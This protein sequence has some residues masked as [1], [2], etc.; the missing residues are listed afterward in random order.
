MRASSNNREEEVH[1]QQ[2]VP[3]Y[4]IV[5][6]TFNEAHRIAKLLDSLRPFL[7]KGGEVVVADSNSTDQTVEIATTKGCRV[8][9][10]GRAHQH[11]VSR[12]ESEQVSRFVMDYPGPT[13]TTSTMTSTTSTATTIGGEEDINADLPPLVEEGSRWF[14]FAGARN[15]AASA[16]SNDFV[17]VLD[18]GDSVELMEVEQIGTIL[19]PGRTFPI[20]HHLDFSS[21]HR[22]VRFYDRRSWRYEGYAH[23]YLHR[24][25]EDRLPPMPAL[26]IGE[27]LLRIRY[28][29]DH[30]KSRPY[31][32]GLY[33][34]LQKN[35][36]SHR[37]HFYL[38]R[39]LFYQKRWNEAIA[40][41]EK[42]VARTA[43]WGEEMSQALVYVGESHVSLGDLE[44]AK[45][46]YHRALQYDASRREPWIRLAY[47]ALVQKKYRLC[48][49]YT[50]AAMQMPKKVSLYE[51]GTNYTTTPPDLMYCALVWLKER[52]E[53][54]PYWKR[55]LELQPT[56]S[57]YLHDRV[58]F[59]GQI[60]ADP[61][62]PQ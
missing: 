9:Q 29:R 41:F 11:L 4:T 24:R 26:P 51:P 46:A 57:R 44:S 43:G 60:A 61:H 22:A 28:R 49:G 59:T 16:A 31:M 52:D 40:V 47:V 37:W 6:L 54:Y 48:V 2:D 42:G 1:E 32:F 23:E 33:L 30:A 5:V 21:T 39:E 13:T 12:E 50:A 36:E 3:K 56:N 58:F 35:P 10:M 15:E 8:V 17:L 19:T 14:D 55:C 25:D 38:G 53:A 62:P 45:T 18:A 7:I 34:N 20:V 27:H